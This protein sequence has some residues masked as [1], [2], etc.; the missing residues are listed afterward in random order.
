MSNQSGATRRLDALEDQSRRDD[1]G[2][3]LERLAVAS[4]LTVGEITVEAE[5]VTMA[6]EGLS[7]PEVL[8]WIA[9]D[10]G[11]SVDALEA[12]ADALL[13]AADH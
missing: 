13:A 3:Y 10:C 7:R 1:L 8:G 4:G 9:A 11:M 6:T 12:E 5:R 2:P